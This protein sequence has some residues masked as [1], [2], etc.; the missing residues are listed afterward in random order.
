M[1]PSIDQAFPT[2][3]SAARFLR[4]LRESLARSSTI[5]KRLMPQAESAVD[6]AGTLAF[7]LRRMARRICLEQSLI[8]TGGG[9]LLS[10]LA[11]SALLHLSIVF[12]QLGMAPLGLGRGD[13]RLDDLV[14][15]PPC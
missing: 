11:L 12:A 1:S 15:D 5:V 2:L 4:V 7:L 6:G 14:V 13:D 3:L 10:E 9:L 8:T